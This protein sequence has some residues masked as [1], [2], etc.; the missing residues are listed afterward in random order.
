MVR[1]CLMKRLNN[2]ERQLSAT[3]W[4]EKMTARFR[5]AEPHFETERELER[6][7]GSAIQDMLDL[8]LSVC[9]VLLRGFGLDLAVFTEKA[10]TARQCC[11]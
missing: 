1:Q 7:I 8:D 9:A 5:P 6:A 4:R 10:G 2:S 11:F 3:F